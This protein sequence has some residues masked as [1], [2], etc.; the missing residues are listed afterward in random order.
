MAVHALAFAQSCKQAGI[1]FPVPLKKIDL[2][3][4]EYLTQEIWINQD[5]QKS[6]RDFVNWANMF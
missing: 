4:L 5:G 2:L 3:P 6:Y 1:F